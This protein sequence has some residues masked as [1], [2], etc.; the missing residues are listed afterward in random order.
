MDTT[1]TALRGEKGSYTQVLDLAYPVVLSMLSWTVL[2]TVDTMFVGRLGTAEQGAVGFAGAL[3]WTMM[4]L[5]TG[6]MIGVQ[7]YVAQHVGRKEYARCGEIC[8]QGIYLALVAALPIMAIGVWGGG[9]VRVF[10]VA[11]ELEPHACVYFRI[12]LAGAWFVFLTFVCEN[13]FRGVGDTKTPMKIAIFAS[14]LNIVLDYGLIFGK[15]GLPRMEV[16]GAALATVITTVIQAGICL[17]VLFRKRTFRDR[18]RT[19]PV[20]RLDPGQLRNIIKIGG[21]VGIQWFLD[22][23]SWA[24]FTAL[25]ARLGAVQA[26]ANQIAITL[27]HVSFMPGHAI[28]MAVTTLVGQYLGAGDR[29]AARRSAANSLRVAVLFMGMMG[30]VFYVLRRPLVRAFNPDPA[31][32]DIGANLLIFAAVF[33]IFD[34]AALVAGGILR[35]AGDT[36]VPA[37]IQIVLAYLLFLPVAY[38]AMARNGFG[39]LGG[40]FGATVYI[41]VLGIVLYARYRR[42]AWSH[43]VLIGEKPAEGKP[44]IPPGPECIGPT[45]D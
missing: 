25:V 21:P 7:I 22:M 9:L 42:G 23:G 39:A 4:T 38:V 14:A 6:T 43:R 41:V 2:W 35:G 13:F 30:L 1:H 44:A 37:A 18:F 10:G 3:T 27:L 11:P 31:V 45:T 26:A 24:I 5:V 34:A 28:S 29:P 20:R 8:W 40:W 36:R 19:L 12:R 16:A 15:L 33:Q 32:I 17:L